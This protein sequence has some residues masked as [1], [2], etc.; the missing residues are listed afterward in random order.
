MNRPKGENTDGKTLMAVKKLDYFKE[1]NN[2]GVP[3][4]DFQMQFCSR[5]LQP[6]CIR[7]QQGR[8]KFDQ[9]VTT[10]ESRL[11]S[12][13]P[14]MSEADPRFELLQ[15]KKFVQV[16][17]DTSRAYGVQ[18]WLDP[19]DV[20][21]SPKPEAPKDDAEACPLRCSSDPEE[22]V[23]PA[24]EARAKNTPN[25]RGQ[26]LGGKKVVRSDPKTVS[27]P[28]ESKKPSEGKVVQ[29]GAKIRFGEPEPV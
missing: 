11:F 12:D 20:K 27:D 1:C 6:E 15:A 25:R 23:P 9:R 16:Q 18:G 5:C 3:I 29:P 17:V 4:E 13:V 22:S 19:L 28:W 8:S 24:T 7:S 14:R 21:E 10:W 26:L 2:H